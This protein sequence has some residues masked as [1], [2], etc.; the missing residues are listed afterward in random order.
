MD[1]K[2]RYELIPM[3][4]NSHLIRKFKKHWWS[5]WQIEMDGEEPKIYPVNQKNCKHDYE[6]V[7]IVIS[8]SYPRGI[9]MEKIRCKKCGYETVRL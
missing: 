5:K 8:D 2:E 7:E 3:R 6:F 4:E 1:Y 9:P